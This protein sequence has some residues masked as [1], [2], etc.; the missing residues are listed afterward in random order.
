VAPLVRENNP[1]DMQFGPD[2]ALY[3]LEY[4]DGF[5]VENADAQ[6]ARIDFVRGN[7]TPSVT[8]E[9]DKTS[10]SAPPLEVH[11]TS[12]ASDPDGDRLTYDW[13]FDADGTVD[14]H[15]ANPTFTYTKIGVFDATLKV[16]DST[17]RSASASVEVVVGNQT[18][19]VTIVKPTADQA[20]HWGDTIQYEVKVEDDQPV[21]CTQV[22]VHFLI[23]HDTHSHDI[24]QTTGC[25]GSLILN[26]G[27]HAGLPNITAIIGAEY[28]D[29][30]FE[31]Q[32][33]GRLTGTA[34]VILHPTS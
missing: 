1:M 19:V 25:T 12:D 31:G 27:D 29:P 10:S 4:G 2:G 18:P 34:Q 11:F 22:T 8:V 13:D 24:S 17:G 33:Q 32:G 6:V 7:R 23:G 20:V 3:T 14:S 9:A 21:D 26:A 16:T 15:E 28:T 30:G 5:F